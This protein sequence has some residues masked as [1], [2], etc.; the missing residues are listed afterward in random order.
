MWRTLF[1]LNTC[2]QLESQLHCRLSPPVISR[3]NPGFKKRIGCVAT[4]CLSDFILAQHFENDEVLI[5]LTSPA[6]ELLISNKPP[7]T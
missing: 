1:L 7:Q 5:N 6:R 3:L 2:R 4:R